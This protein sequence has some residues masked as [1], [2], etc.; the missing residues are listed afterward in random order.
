MPAVFVSVVLMSSLVFAEPPKVFILHSYHQAS[1]W[2]GNIMQGMMSVF[3]ESG[4]EIDIHVEYMDTE[5][6]P[7][8][9]TGGRLSAVLSEKYDS[10]AFDVI[11]VVDQNALQFVLS[12]RDS[13]F[14]GVPVVF[15]GIN[16]FREDVIEGQ[17]NITGVNQ[18]IDIGGTVSLARR[19]KPDIRKFLVVN[20][21]TAT[22]LAN[23]ER[24]K[25][26]AAGLGED[27]PDFELIDDFTLPELQARLAGLPADAAVLVLRLHQING[28]RELSPDGYLNIVTGSS[29][30]PVFKLWQTDADD[31]TMG[32]VLVSGRAQGASAARYVLRI[33]RGEPADSLPVVM[34]SPNVSVVDWRQLHRFNIPVNRV[35][36]GTLVLHTPMS[37]FDEYHHEI[38][39]AVFVFVAL[40]ITIVALFIV[41]LVRR[42]AENELRQSENRAI[43]AKKEWEH[44]F[45]AVL[46]PMMVL[47]LEYRVRRVNTAMSE[48]LGVSPDALVGRTCH[49]IVHGTIEPP[50]ACPYSRLL[51]AGE[52]C[53]AEVLESRLGG[54]FQI[55]VFPTFGP[56]GQLTGA[57]HFA[58]DI[59]ERKRE[60]R[61]QTAKLRL[62][63]Y[64]PDH[65]ET[66]LLSKFLEEAEFMT[67]SR[68][69]FFHYLSE[70][71]GM[72]LLNAWSQKTLEAGCRL[73]VS[74]GHY[75]V[76]EAGVWL[77]CVRERRP[78]IHNDYQGLPHKKGLP[79]GHAPIFRELLYPIF[80]K[81]NIVAIMGLGNKPTDYGPHDIETIRQLAD[82][83][84]EMVVRKQ[85]EAETRR[86]RAISDKALHGNLVVDIDSDKILYA[87]EYLA[88]IYGYAME[89]LIGAPI[90]VLHT[91]K[92]MQEALK[93]K[94]VL[95]EEGSFS[96]T[97]LISRHKNGLDL[98]VLLSG[99]LLQG[100]SGSPRY[101][102]ASI[103]DISERKRLEQQLQQ[104]QK[105]ESIGNLAGG[106]A[107]D[108]NNILF[109]IVGMA[110]LLMEDLPAGSI[111]RENAE[112][113]YRAGTRG[114]ELVKQ[115]LAFSRR[116]EHRKIPVHVQ[117]I[118]KEV[119]RL[120][121]ATIPADI[122]IVR[123]VQKDCGLVMADA[124][125]VHQVCINLITN[126]YHAVE[127]GGGS[128]SVGLREIEWEGRG[129]DVE[130]PG[131]GRYVR[132]TVSDTGCGM[133][134]FTLEKIFE[135]YFTTKEQGKGTGL[136]MS[137]VYG[138]V[139]EHKG[140]IRIASRPGRGTT[141]E[142]FFPAM[143]KGA[144]QPEGAG[145][146]V[147]V[148]TGDEHILLV[149]DE[150]A[151][152]K[153]EK[154]MLESLGYRVTAFTHGR[155]AVAAF[156]AAPYNY[157][158]V[159]SDMTMP[160][161]TGDRLAEKILL[162][163]PEIPVIICTGFSERIDPG[164]ADAIGIRGLLTKPV[165][166]ADFGTMIRSVLDES[167]R[168]GPN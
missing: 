64:A 162:V 71:D 148:P 12:N 138:I 44:T 69:S 144:A 19:I 83:A 129:D 53:S 48:R 165:Q 9:F 35:P 134:P 42:R 106:I 155:D 49:S 20:D 10:I 65:S 77:D 113:I 90:S 26:Y 82:M 161:I 57:V 108:F 99:V 167:R 136:G 110:E 132:L 60:E 97:E 139:K 135:P 122:D 94:A 88:N 163:R 147:R 30:V 96:P 59:T 29:P 145:A 160:G 133:E 3:D 27:S 89:E 39:G 91:E 68:I 158:L 41:I 21:R 103:V 23:R 32:G 146:S 156:E 13:L 115:I 85:A 66:E 84:W 121:R 55:S 164:K 25:D 50:P 62:I 18:S 76:S 7:K 150:A 93:L 73:P 36:D 81:D 56:D 100:D 61:L 31:D 120:T 118:L 112:E 58:R 4:L 16:N 2:T 22:G 126:A 137:V 109:P 116:S 154:R 11:L 45:D 8:A 51:A 125:Q 128:I 5:R 105:M 102:A 1:K 166:K 107:H 47:D 28:V 63:E 34:N 70:D 33:L 80:R 111:E 153:L 54:D 141:V 43:R 123:D 124:V 24:F 92:Q 38:L 14:P 79:D 15:C 140:D 87:N 149:D 101:A 86:F 114:S 74:S 152:V 6:L 157:D 67:G 95:L 98:P 117:Q 78:V 159:V 143:E 119:F 142:V 151:V 72:V 130:A 52:A 40:V 46:D 75:P 104:A 17:G 127:R 168:R 37:V 131:P